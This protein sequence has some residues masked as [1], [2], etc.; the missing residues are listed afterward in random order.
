[1]ITLLVNVQIKADKTAEFEA[2]FSKIAA[3]VRAK[4]PGT[5]EYRIVRS[6]SDA[7]QYRVIEHYQSQD[8]ADAHRNNP[9]IRD[10]LTSLGETLAGKPSLEIFDEVAPG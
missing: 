6:R 9:D 5:H 3:I 1:M 4:E 7:A 2:T 8:A 10:L